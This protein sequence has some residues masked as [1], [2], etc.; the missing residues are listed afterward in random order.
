ML[1]YAVI[2]CIKMVH[3]SVGKK[4]LKR[5]RIKQL[6]SLSGTHTPIVDACYSPGPSPVSTELQSYDQHFSLSTLV[7]LRKSGGSWRGCVLAI[8]WHHFDFTI[9][10]NYTQ[11]YICC[12]GS[13]T[14][15]NWLSSQW[16]LP[17]SSQTFFLSSLFEG[18]FL[19]VA[20]S[21]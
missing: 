5:R 8:S 7:C 19:T 12:F 4:T 20:S 16:F 9:F 3:C 14:P 15:P 21:S 1:A 11:Q 6:W 10:I 13:D 18:W 17:V 2:N